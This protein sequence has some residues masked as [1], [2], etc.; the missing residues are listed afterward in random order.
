MNIPFPTVPSSPEA[1]KSIVTILPSV[2]AAAT[3]WTGS[4][5][6]TSLKTNESS[7]KKKSLIQKVP[8]IF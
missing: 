8:R 5:A 4:G 3:F 7:N 6:T 2:V 1:S